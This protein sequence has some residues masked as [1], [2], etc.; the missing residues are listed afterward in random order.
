MLELYQAEWCPFSHQV[1]QRLT[2][3]GLDFV[4]RQVEPEPHL[5]DAMR[6]AVGS[7]SVPVLVLDDGT[8]LDGHADEIVDELDRHF[9]ETEFTAE[10]HERRV[11]AA[12]FEP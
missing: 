12:A 6:E 1:R 8:V 5:R 9:P 2:E 4:A 7:D 10:H 3:L 11:E